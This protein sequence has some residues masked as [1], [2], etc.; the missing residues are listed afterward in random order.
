MTTDNYC[1]YLQNRLIQTCQTGGQ[2][3]S[4]TAPFSILWLSYPL[5]NTL[6]YFFRNINDEE[7]S[8]I[9]LALSGQVFPDE[10][11]EVLAAGDRR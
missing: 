2:W 9:K 10:Y 6:A 5:I 7:N 3:Y 4:D 1:F 8:F 11:E